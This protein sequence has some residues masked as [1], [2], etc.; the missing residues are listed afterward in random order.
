VDDT[1]CDLSLTV[2]CVQFKERSVRVDSRAEW[3]EVEQE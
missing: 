1:L 2:T 3:M